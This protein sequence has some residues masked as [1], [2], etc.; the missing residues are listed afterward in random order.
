MTEHPELRGKTIALVGLMGAGKTTLGRRLAAVLD[1]PFRDSDAE[2]ELAAG[3]TVAEIFEQLGEPAFRAGE[4]RVIARL[5]G[6]PPHVLATGGGAFLDPRTRSLIRER[7]VTI[8]LK[9]DLEILA[10]RVGKR[11]GRPL[12][13]GR[14]P[15]EVLKAQAESRYPVYAEADLHVEVADG[16]HQTALDLVLQALR[17]HVKGVA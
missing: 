4:H 17:S 13:Q 8:W 2:I 7:A 6:D 10:R 12:L 3:C 1:L 11:G 16:V 15:L 9:A 14:D 5:L